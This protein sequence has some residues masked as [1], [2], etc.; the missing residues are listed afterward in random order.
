[1][2]ERVLTPA[3]VRTARRGWRRMNSRSAD[4]AETYA[5]TPSMTSTRQPAADLGEE[6]LA[7]LGQ[8]PGRRGEQIAVTEP[9]HRAL[10]GGAVVVHRK[11]RVQWFAFHGANH[12]SGR[13]NRG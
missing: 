2:P 12:R 9:G 11:R 3:P 13:L 7:F 6:R 10:Q 5:R 1:M 4:I 8:P